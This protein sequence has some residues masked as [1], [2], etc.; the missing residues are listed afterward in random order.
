ME[1]DTAKIDEFMVAAHMTH[2]GAVCGDAK[3]ATTE[4]CAVA[5]AMISSV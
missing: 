4:L 5:G 1:A 3:R 2:W